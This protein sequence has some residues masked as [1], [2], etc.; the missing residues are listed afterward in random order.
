M[1][2]FASLQLSGNAL[3]AQQIGLHVVGNN[4]ANA[5]TPGYI[6]EEVQYSPAPVLELGNLTLG[7]GVEV[8]AIVQKVD[9]FLAERVRGAASD[10]AGAEVQSDAYRDVETLLG[11]LSDT[12]LSTGLSKFFNA[13][14][15]LEQ[16]PEDLSIRNLAI[17]AGKT[18]TADIRRLADRTNQLHRDLDRRVA[19]AAG[20]INQLAEDVRLLNLRI[21]E[22]EGGSASASEAGGLRTERN[23][24]VN[25]LAELVDISTSEQPNGVLNVSIGGEFLVFGGISRDVEAHTQA[26][27]DRDS[28]RLRFAD[29][30]AELNLTGGELHGLYAAR[31]DITGAFLDNLDEFVGTLAYEF[32][33]LYSQGQ[34]ISGFRELTAKEGVDDAD[35]PLDAAGLPFTPSNGV[36]QLLVFSG[37]NEGPQSTDI[38]VDLNGLDGDTSLNSLA[39]QIDAVDGVS[40]EIDASGRLGVTADSE[41]V[42]FAFSEDPDRPSGALA[43]LGLNTFFVGSTAQDIG[44]NDEL[45]GVQNAAKF[46]ASL[47]GEI[48]QNS[49][50]QNALRLAEFFDRGLD[51]LDGASLA[52]QY[53]EMVNEVTTGATIAASVTEGFRT[54]E[55]SL[56]G[57]EQA[58]S[59]VNIDEEAINMIQLQ[60]SYQATARLV[61]AIS[62]MLDVLVNL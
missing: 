52:D 44:V 46:A 2:L 48:G 33:K 29:N 24:A 41:D 4:I 27:G 54:F 17:G 15:E 18:L 20:E 56:Q 58:I 1:S 19:N 7:L 14:V 42:Q 26:T 38:A 13:L 36:F 11:E 50:N 39:A 21:A 30:N 5:N 34:G 23:N 62:E 16:R 3:R 9:R 60:R 8:D 31:D 12:D 37:E 61:Q 53:D 28:T 35:A 51:A 45:N 49:D 43:A 32:N 25:R 55:A 22:S 6:R 40:A 47:S 57:E 59:G 10:R